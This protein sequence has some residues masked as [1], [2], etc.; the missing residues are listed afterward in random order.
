MHHLRVWLRAQWTAIRN[1]R[2]RHRQ[3]SPYVYVP[4]FGLVEEIQPE[5]TPP[6]RLL[7]RFGL[8]ASASP[9]SVLELERALEQIAHDP[10]VR[11]AVLRLECNASAAT[12]QSLRSA[13]QRLRANSKRVIAYAT[14][15]SPF[16]YYVACACDQII[17][18]P[19]GV[20]NVIGIA[21]EYVF[22]K[23]ALEQIGVRAEVVSVS[24]FKSAGDVFTRSDFSEASRAQAEWLLEARYAELVRGIAEG[25]KLAEDA[26]RSLIDRAPLS[27]REAQAAGL[28]DALAY[29]DEI[30]SLLEAEPST[31]QPAR[32]RW[33]RRWLTR[34]DRQQQSARRLMPLEQARKALM[35]RPQTFGWRG[36]GVVHVNGV[37]VP[38]SAPLPISRG[39]VSAQAVIRALRAAERNPAVAAI[40]M[41]VNSNGGEAL[42]S[43][44]IAHEVA[45][46]NRR[47]PI[48]AYLGSVAAS[49]GYYIAAPARYI[50]AQSLT[51]TGSIGVLAVRF[52][53]EG[54][55]QR[56]GVRQVV[57]KRGANADLLNSAAPLNEAQRAIIERQV[58]TAYEDFK[59]LV[60]THRPITEE[61]FERIGGGRVWTGAQALTHGLVDALGDFKRALEQARSLAHLPPDSP[62]YDVTWSTAETV[63]PD[64]AALQGWLAQL[65]RSWAWCLLPWQEQ[66]L[67]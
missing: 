20:W 13:I 33:F 22:L 63:L 47:K 10:R 46:V 43:D 14:T 52:N 38:S 4:V 1:A 55:L 8:L 49:G 37:I 44:L 11:G 62:V 48:V 41:V 59:R 35:L 67:Q 25:R 2:R 18:P 31:T 57:L 34:V 16:Q 7:R 51:I 42:A 3:L 36:I 28:I 45:R 21:S 64:P 40:V 54:A 30:E 39:I 27:A 29:E 61:A 53:L 24:P 15:F 17:M 56:L 19:T 5:A 6:A 66:P 50:I 58:T 26:V 65:Q 60:L 23:E 32:A 12:F 9:N